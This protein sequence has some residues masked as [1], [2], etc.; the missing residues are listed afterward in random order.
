M[1]KLLLFTIALFAGQFSQAQWEPDV[2]LTNNAD[3]SRIFFGNIHSIAA[4]GDT[5]HVVWYDKSDGNWEI[6][7]MRSIDE[8]INWEKAIRLTNDPARSTHASIAVYGLAVHIFWCEW[9]PGNPEI[10]YTHSTDGGSTWEDEQRLTDDPNNSYGPAVS[11]SGSYVH[12]VW[13]SYDYNSG[14]YEVHYK[15]SSDGGINWGDEFCL[16]CNS[17]KAYNASIAVSGS[18]VYVVWYDV[19][20]NNAEIY[21][22]KSTDDGLNWE[23]E[24]LLTGDFAYPQMPSIAASGSTVH[25]VW[26]DLRNGSKIYY[27]GSLDGGA[28]WCEDNLISNVPAISSD[29]NLA[30][31]NSVL[32]VVWQDNRNG[33][34]DIFYNYSTDGGK[35]WNED[36]RLNDWSWSSERPFIAISDTVLHVIWQDYRDGNYEIYYKRN[37]TGNLPV[38]IED[39]PSLPSGGQLSVYPNPASKQ[40]TVSSQQSAIINQQS[41]INNL[42]SAINLSI[43]D[44]YG[45]TIKEIGDVPSFPYQLDISDLT[46]GIYILRIND[47]EG[48]LTSTKF[49]KISE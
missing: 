44:I 14:D 27:K 48:S 10:Y 3:S 41:E 36:T 4:S 9:K 24:F 2:R 49:L 30:V 43:V 11:V 13:V 15:H 18:D 31:S 17:L 35:T 16:S 25:V 29:P 22:R 45:R 47:K 28:N 40:L 1:K 7:Y 42:K 39:E 26:W 46:D 21:L 6:Y 32:H 8:G 23:P 5:I 33:V 38:S 34:P 12:L 20:D 19:R 37:P